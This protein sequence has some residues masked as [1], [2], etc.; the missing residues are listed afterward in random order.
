MNGRQQSAAD[1]ASRDLD[2]IERLGDRQRSVGRQLARCLD[3]AD[4]KGARK[5]WAELQIIERRRARLIRFLG[6]AVQLA[7]KE[8]SHVGALIMA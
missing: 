3:F 2:L 6:E 1:Q 7:I 8:D 4:A 5:P